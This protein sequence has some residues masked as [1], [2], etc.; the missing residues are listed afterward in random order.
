MVL[1]QSLTSLDCLTS[2]FATRTSLHL[3]SWSLPSRGRLFIFFFFFSSPWRCSLNHWWGQHPTSSMGFDN[4]CL[5]RRDL[6][7]LVMHQC[8]TN[9]NAWFHRMLFEVDLW[10][11]PNRG[12]KNGTSI[13]RC[14]DVFTPL[15]GSSRYSLHICIS[16]WVMYHKTCTSW[17]EYFEF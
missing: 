3:Q 5:Q 10:Q 14:L 6:L 8:D 12:K 15:G 1:T 2:S 4:I 7:G 9:S 11:E 13:E 16:S 17:F